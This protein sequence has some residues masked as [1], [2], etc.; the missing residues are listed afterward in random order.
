LTL[1]TKAPGRRRGGGARAGQRPDHP[2]GDRLG[3]VDD[4]RDGIWF[5]SLEVGIVAMLAARCAVGAPYHLGDLSVSEHRGTVIYAGARRG[6][7][8]SYHLVV[9]PGD[10]ILQP[11]DRDIWL[12]GRWRAYTRRFG[13]LF[14]TPSSMSRGH[15]PPASS[16]SSPKRW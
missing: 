5:L 12:T 14:E 1:I 2:V 3:P 10:P 11:S 4:G 15:W 9:R 16:R 6:G 7:K 13:I 8:P